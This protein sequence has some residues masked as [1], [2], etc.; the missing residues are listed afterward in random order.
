MLNNPNIIVALDHG[1][2]DTVRMLVRQLSPQHCHLKIGN[3]LFTQHG[4]ALV[5]ELMRDGFNVFLDLKYHDIPQTVAAS[6]RAAA[7]ASVWMVNMHVSSGVAAMR[8]AAE[9]IQTVHQ[10]TSRRT[11]LIGVTVLTSLDHADLQTLGI[12]RNVEQ[13]VL[14]MALTAQQCGLDGVV[15]SSQEAAMLRQHCGPD[16]ILV[17]PGIRLPTSPAD[18][19]KRIFTPQQALMAGASYLVVGR[20]ITQAADPCAALQSFF[21]L[22]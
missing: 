22:N 7:E 21:S 11:W 19:Q 14:H 9:T 5:Q 1:T 16:F 2:L 12:Q 18:D 3:I 20:P 15:C 4:P 8:L 10:K 17:T 13:T 6:C